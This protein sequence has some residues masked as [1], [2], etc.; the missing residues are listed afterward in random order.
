M[1]NLIGEVFGK[2]KVI[3]FAD[4]DIMKGNRKRRRWLC[5]CECGTKRTVIES[6]LLNG[7]SKSCGCYHSEIMREVGRKL[8]TTHGMTDTRLYRIY[9]HMINRYY[10]EN[11]IRYEK[12]G[13]RGIRVVDEW[14]SFEPFMEWAIANGYNDHLSIDRID[15]NGNYSPE[16]CR[17][18]DRTTQANNKT[19]N[20]KY[21][22]QGKTLTIA[23]WAREYDMHYKKLW[24]RLHNGWSIEQALTT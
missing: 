1:Q 7:L 14:L 8:F 16:N 13:K 15:V 6:S 4:P 23:E 2:W 5:Q 3:D 19:S 12:Y 11:D 22:Y 24:K 21:S 9:Q 20:Q 18:A 10:N 17:W